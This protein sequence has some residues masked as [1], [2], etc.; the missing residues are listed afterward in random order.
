MKAF[1]I[2]VLVTWTFVAKGQDIINWDGVYQ[3]QLSDFRSAGTKIEEMDVFTLNSSCTFDF[4]FRMS[5]AEFMFTKNFNSKVNTYFKP[6]LATLVAPDT[7]TAMNLVAFA[8]FE[9]DLSELYA[10]KFRKKLFEEKG[11]FSSAAF[12]QPSYEQVHNEMSQRHTLVGA[13]TDVG[14]NREKLREFHEAVRL[15][16]EALKDFCKSCKPPKKTKGK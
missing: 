11:A 13:E 5:N 10:R 2:I 4:V 15:E 3:I 12:F 14:M 6:N 1:V 9:F 7:A 8:R 16:I